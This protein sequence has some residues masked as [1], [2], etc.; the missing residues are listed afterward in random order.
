M[1]DLMEGSNCAGRFRMYLYLSF[2][3]AAMASLMAI[4]IH[5]VAALKKVPKSKEAP[6]EVKL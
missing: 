3:A 2:H 5:A 1:S 6:K 4:F